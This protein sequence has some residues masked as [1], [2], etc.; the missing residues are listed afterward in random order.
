MLHCV[1]YTAVPCG[2]VLVTAYFDVQTFFFGCLSWFS[3]FFS[4]NAFELSTSK[5]MRPVVG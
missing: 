2:A 3:C 5:L 4:G 1:V